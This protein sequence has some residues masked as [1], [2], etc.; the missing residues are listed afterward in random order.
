MR[1]A[2][3]RILSVIDRRIRQGG[4]LPFAGSTD[5]FTAGNGSLSASLPFRWRS[6]EF[7]VGDPQRG[8]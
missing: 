8:E 1:A 3:F 2:R 4:Y 6:G 7:W 5:L